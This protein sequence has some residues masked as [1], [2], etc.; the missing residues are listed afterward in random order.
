VAIN[1]SYIENSMLPEILNCA[2]FITIVHPHA[3]LKHIFSLSSDGGVYSLLVMPPTEK[4]HRGFQAGQTRLQVER[5]CRV[6]FEKAIPIMTSQSRKLASDGCET[7]T[8]LI[9]DGP[10][11]HSIP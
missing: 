5:G 8:K 9:C 2:L 4:N 6:L 3:S 7:D 11:S 1:K 10:T